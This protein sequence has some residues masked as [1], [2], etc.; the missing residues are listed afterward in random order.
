LVAAANI[1]FQK[2]NIRCDFMI[3]ALA[4]GVGAAR[5]LT[6]LTQLVAPKDLTVI[7]NT[8]DDKEFY[9]LH[10]SA[11]VDIVTY[12]LAGIVDNE[13][14]W[15]IAGDTF[16]TLGMLKKYGQENWFNIGDRDFATH[17][18]RT[19]LIKQG[20]TLTQ[21]TAQICRCLSVEA[22]ILPMTDDF[23]ET[24]VKTPSGTIHFEDYM[25]KNGAKD[26]V[27]GVEFAGSKT[28]KPA[29]GVLEAIMDSELVVICPSNPIV[30]IGAILSVNGVR[31]ALQKTKAKKVA[32][33][34]IVAGVPIKGPADKLMRGLGLEVSAFSVAKIYRDFLDVFIIDT[35]DE[36]EKSRI[37]GLGVKVKVMNTVMMRLE[38]KVALAKAVLGNI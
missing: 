14:G 33:S 26:D 7:V 17:I 35:L 32:V 23:F 3:T 4:G 31:E 10:V 24:R 36:D 16:E 6:G 30:S 15:G 22:K 20:S 37:E 9:G 25:V 18:L 2:K 13:K 38:D 28:A 21:V 11:D 19:S 27:L 1:G 29:T 8:G 12:T 34:P 5:F